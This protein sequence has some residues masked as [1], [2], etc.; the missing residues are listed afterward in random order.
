MGNSEVK[1]TLANLVRLGLK[2]EGY[3]LVRWLSD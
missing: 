2:R 1:A 3:G